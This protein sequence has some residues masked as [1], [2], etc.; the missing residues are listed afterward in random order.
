MAWST[1]EVAVGSF[2][3]HIY[4]APSA[5]KARA[6]AWRAYT[7]A[8]PDCT[9]KR[10]L[11]ISRVKKCSPPA[12]TSDGYDYVRR[13]YGV[14]PRIGQRARLVNEGP[15]TGLEGEVIYPGRTTAHVHIVIDGRDFAVSV[16]PMSIDLLGATA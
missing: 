3:P 2:E 5:G 11:Q 6:E 16:H 1:Y 10:F 15:S 7:S 12:V 4:S 14:D 9:F 8:Y 13:A